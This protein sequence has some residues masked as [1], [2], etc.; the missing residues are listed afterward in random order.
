MKN[1]LVPTDFSA[2]SHHAFNVALQMARR[3]GSSV[4]L[5]HVVA[6]PEAA[7]GSTVGGPAGELEEEVD[8]NKTKLQQATKRRMQELLNEAGRTSPNVPVHGLVLNASTGP[9]ILQDIET[10]HIDLVVI[11]AQI[12]A[13]A[14]QLP[15]GSHTE[16]LIRLASCPVLTVKYAVAEFAPGRILFP[17]NFTAETDRAVAGLRQVQALF[18]EAKLY[19]LQVVAAEAE[20][21]G[22]LARIIVFARRHDL[23]HVQ[24]AV[25]IADGPASGI[26]SYARQIQADLLVMPTHGR[27][28]PARL[29]QASIAENVAT[30]A[31][32]P[33]LTFRPA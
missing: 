25:F 10:Q 26:P 5:L 14:A 15:D 21:A 22:T 28:G 6:V 19:L 33:V 16:E 17:S 1:L 12:H 13:G 32:P 30:H 4:T 9:A 23:A 27:T 24:P 20:F 31:F 11:G 29:L 8:E 2:E 7:G 3:L 18:P